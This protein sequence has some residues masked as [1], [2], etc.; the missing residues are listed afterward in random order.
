M[1]TTPGGVLTFS[2]FQQSF[3]FTKTQKTS[4][5]A[6]AVGIQQAGAFAGCFLIW[7]VTNTLGRRA[8]MMICSA[9]FCMGVILEV[10]DTHSLPAFYVGRVICGLGVGGSATVIPI[11]MSEMSPKEIRGQLGSC[12][13]LTYTIGILVSY[14]IDYGVKG[15]PATARQWQ[16]PIGLQLVPGFLMGVGVLSL[17]ESVRW[18]LANGREEE[19]WRSLVWIRAGEGQGVVG[20]FE[21]MRRG[22]EEERGCYR[23]GFRVRELLG[24]AESASVVDWWGV[25]SGAAVDWVDC[26]GV[27]W[28]AVFCDS[29]WGWG[30]HFVAYGYLWCD[31]GCCLCDFCGVFV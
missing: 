31:Q 1:L 9:V 29:C 5:S 14:W 3:N 18:L 6:I 23:A 17:S 21:G 26:V 30:S 22:L 15:M 19:A 2:S 13:Q 25:V 8:A 28:T 12:Y 10:I 24:V 7:P 16:L 11:Y 27:F 20:E 4:I